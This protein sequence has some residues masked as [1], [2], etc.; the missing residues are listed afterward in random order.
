MSAS[1]PTITTPL[2]H[3]GST[4]HCIGN[5]TT[6]DT[7]T[8]GHPEIL[9]NDTT[10]AELCPEPAERP[11]IYRW[12][13]AATFFSFIVVGAIDGAYGVWKS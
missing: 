11:T 5:T 6:A 2:L 12:R 3:G 13:I 9:I 10:T 4:I 7:T 8:V 1:H